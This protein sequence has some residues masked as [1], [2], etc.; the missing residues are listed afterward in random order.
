[1]VA[2]AK[3]Y[4]KTARVK[5]FTA[6]TGRVVNAENHN[7]WRNP[8]PEEKKTQK[9][10]KDRLPLWLYPSTVKMMDEAFPPNNFKSR[11][12]FI[13][14]AIQFFCGYLSAANALDFLPTAIT[15]AVS[16]AVQSSENRMAR[17]LFKL[18]VEMSIMTTVV[19]ANTTDLDDVGLK[20]LRGKCV[21]DVKKT[22]GAVNFD[23][24][25]RYQRGES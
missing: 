20:R 13:E 10:R 9:E 7:D 14:K 18:A 2:G 12:E 1:V 6:S 25:L 4:G 24:A 11:S 16:G 17:L 15:S 23:E 8:M 22:I 19:A 5:A 21:E 3:K